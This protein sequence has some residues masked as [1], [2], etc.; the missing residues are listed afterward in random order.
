MAIW[1]LDIELTNG[2]FFIFNLKNNIPMYVNMWHQNVFMLRFGK[3][4]NKYTFAKI[5]IY[6]RF[7]LF[8]K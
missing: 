2:P 1:S 8:S 4:Y 3:L 7:D 5:E 6:Q